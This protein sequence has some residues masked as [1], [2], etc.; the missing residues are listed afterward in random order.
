MLVN[1][2]FRKSAVLLF[3]ALSLGA[4]ACQEETTAPVVRRIHQAYDL[5]S[6]LD[7]EA[8]ALSDLNAVSRKSVS[9]D[10][11]VTEAKIISTINW[12]E[13]LGSFADA[14]INR[15]ALAGV[16]TK[17]VSSDALGQQVHRYKAK[18][19][20]ST[21]IQQVTYTLDA[22]GQLVQLDATIVQE[23][24]LFKTQKLL[25]L[26]AHSG[27]SPRLVRYFLDETQKLMLMDAQ[28]YTITGEVAV[29]QTPAAL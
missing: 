7:Q 28:R 17:E 2:W 4:S 23:N 29:K 11:S 14:D 16:F 18:E 27:P 12:A 3:T 22:K 13:E 9:Q 15:P 20:A 5:V 1:Q 21:N 8:K 24:F 25:H 26:E 6:F 19:D 10:G